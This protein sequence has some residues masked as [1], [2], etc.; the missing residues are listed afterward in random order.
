MYTFLKDKILDEENREIMM[1]WETGL[2]QEHAKVVTENGGDILEI[3]FGMG[4]CANFIQQANINTHTIIEIHD[5]IFKHLL[6]WAKDKPNVIPIKGDWF[7]SIPKNKKYD[8]IMHDTWQEKN[9]HHF[10]A[11]VQTLLKSKGIVTY[12]NAEVKESLEFDINKFKWCDLS[13]KEIK[14]NPPKNMNCQYYYRDTYL[15]PKLVYNY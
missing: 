10:F 11:K 1:D 12:Y 5:E 15:I 14:V 6:E 7:D 4:I 3:G 2:M 8:G 9:F 13:I